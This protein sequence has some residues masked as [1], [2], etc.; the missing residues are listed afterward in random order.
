MRVWYRVLPVGICLWLVACGAN[1]PPPSLAAQTPLFST[2]VATETAS[3]SGTPTPSPTNAATPNTLQ[4]ITL[5]LWVPEEFAPGAERGGDVLERQLVEFEATHPNIRIQYV[6]KAPYGKGGLVDWLIQL[7]ELMPDQL[8]DAVIVDSRELDEL[9][10]LGLL[11]PLQRDLPA[12]AFWDLFPPAQRIARQRGHWNNQPLVLETEHLVYDARRLRAPPLS[13]QDVLSDTK[14]FAFAADSTE[15]FLF[16]Y[17]QNGGSV[18]PRE[19]SALGSG[20]MQAILDYYQRVRANGN[21]N[22][23]TAVMKSAREVM[24]LFV[25][26]QAPMAQVRARDFLIE[27]ENLPNARAA[28]IPTRD[29]SEAALVSGWSY[30][31]I[32]DDPPRQRAAGEYLAWMIDPGRMAE[33]SGAARLLPASTSAFAQSQEPPEYADVLWGLLEHAIV[34][35]GFSQQAPFA[36][37]WHAAV[38]AVMNGQLAPDDAAVRAVQAILQ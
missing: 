3:D 34:A 30:V 37:A 24:P 5:T 18:D 4:P 2:P 26:G 32:S 38:T 9:G 7:D 1:T 12:G 28:A 6:L 13:W 35:P 11:Q 25:S 29:G 23:T 16:Q 36:D 8:P 14:Q 19:P 15:A 17:L 10:K 21:L 20:I 22:E 31:V 33:W 27:R